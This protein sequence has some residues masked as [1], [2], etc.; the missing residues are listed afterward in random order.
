[1][2][3]LFQSVPA[4]SSLRAP[5]PYRVVKMD[6]K[7]IMALAMMALMVIPSMT[8]TVGASEEDMASAIERARIYLDKVRKIADNMA[9]E[10]QGNVMMQGYLDQLYPLLGQYEYEGPEIY[11]QEEGAG[12][13]EWSDDVVKSGLISA[14]LSDEGMGYDGGPPEV[15]GAGRVVIPVDKLLAD[16]DSLSYWFWYSCPETHPFYF[17]YM[18]LAIDTTGG[19]TPNQWLVME[20]PISVYQPAEDTWT[21][22]DADYDL[23]HTDGYTLMDTLDVLKSEYPDAKVLTV[24]IAVGEWSSGSYSPITAYVD[25]IEIDG[26]TY[27]FE[28]GEAEEGTVKDYLDQASECLG[29]KDFKSAA[30]NLSAARNIL[31]RVKGLLR[32]MAKAHKVARTA[33]FER[34]FQRRIQG[35]EDKIEK[36]KGPKK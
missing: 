4:G 11:F 17:P 33:R 24:K 28:E 35:I 14:Y 16:I 31:G 30:R 9:D 20:S 5:S 26:V 23:W 10:Y 13:A 34:K 18:I 3:W 32:S 22:F 6:L 19:M 25:D 29:E 8:V 7:K 36:P 27:D 1:M 15:Y 21:K 2:E 12:I